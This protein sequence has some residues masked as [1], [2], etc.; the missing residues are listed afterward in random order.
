MKE[1]HQLLQNI[2]TCQPVVR[3]ERPEWADV[4]YRGVR[5]YR[6]LD[7]GIEVWKGGDGDLLV[8]ASMYSG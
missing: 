6:C 1:N 2:E 4:G 7:L 3:Q 5:G 8:G